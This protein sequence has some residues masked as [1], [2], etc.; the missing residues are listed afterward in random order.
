MSSMPW[1]TAHLD[2]IRRAKI[3]AAA[4]PGAVAAEMV[5]DAPYRPTWAWVTDLERSVRSFD[6]QVT[7]IRVRS[8]EATDEPGVER[9]RIT[10]TTRGVVPLR[11]DVRLEDGFCLMRGRARLYLVVMAAVPEGDNRTRFLHMEGVPLPGGR[12]LRPILQREVRSDLR[13]LKRLA[14]GLP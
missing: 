12:L 3:L 11:F 8:R 13:N 1:P 6:Q 5:I 10:A 4:I 14:E 2:P 9:L 7:S